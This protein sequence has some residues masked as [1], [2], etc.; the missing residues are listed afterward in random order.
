MRLKGHFDFR[1]HFCLVFEFLSY[2]L[3]DLIRNTSFKGISLNLIR[4]FAQQIC[5]AL[6]FL[7]T[8]EVSIIHCDLKPENILLKNPKRTAIKLIDFGS[9]CKVGKTMY[10]YI[11]SRFYRSPEVLLGLPYNQ[12]IDMW[13]LGCIL[14][15]LHTGDPIFNGT[16]ESDQ[17][18]K[19]VEVLGMPPPAMLAAGRKA[20]TYFRRTDGPG[21]GWER[22]QTKK[23]YRPAGS[24]LLSDMLGSDIGGP[25]GRRK[26]ELGH[27][28]QDYDL[29]EDLLRRLLDFDPSTRMTPREALD[30]EFLR[31][32]G[33]LPAA[34]RRAAGGGAVQM[35]VE[36]PAAR[37]H[38]P[39]RGAPKPLDSRRER[40]GRASV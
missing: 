34:A 2:N 8:P 38:L 9:S 20:S 25:G 7:S 19:L 17:V 36:Q 14:Y 3:Y 33:P 35:E 40:S 11:Q 12:A 5:T 39:P 15:E 31:R 24:R 29:F 30:H 22:M 37:G 4:K 18:Y 1:S 26:G 28:K 16:S 10:P 13:S 6:L 32:T 21:D 27:K 23:M